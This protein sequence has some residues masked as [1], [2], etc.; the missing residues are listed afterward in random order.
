M[1]A[2]RCTT[3]SPVSAASGMA[4]I[5]VKPKPSASARK[6]ESMARIDILGPIHLVHL[7]DGED[8]LLDADEIANGGVATGLPLHA[9]AG[10]DEEDGEIG[11]ARAGRHVAGILL[12]AGGID[13]DE[14]AVG[15][16]K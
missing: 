16:S 5:S 12:V 6:S 2:E 4:M 15:V 8:D 11:V 1:F 10:V 14:A 7:V 3:L 9:V 13:D